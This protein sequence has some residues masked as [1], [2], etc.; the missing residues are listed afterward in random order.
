MKRLC[1]FLACLVLV[2]INLVQAQTVRI[3]GTVKSSEDGMPIPGVSVIVKGTTTGAAT[4]IDGKYELNVAADAQTLVFSSVGFKSQEVEIG[5]RSL[6]DITLQSE[7]LQVEELVVT[8]V[9]IKRSS[10]SVGYAV[11][12]VNAENATA[13]AEPD[14]LKSIQGRVPGVDVR[15]GQGAP[16]SAT[17]ISIRGTSSFFGSNQPL[18]VVDGVPYS[19]DQ[20]TTSSM[21]SG[22]GAYSN[23]LSTLDPNNIESM[24]VLK[25]SAASALYGSRAANGVLV[26]KT[27][28]GAKSSSKRGYEVTFTSSY[29]IE[30][31]AN[32]PKYQNSYGNGANFEFSNANGS[33]GARFGTIDSIPAWPEYLANYPELYSKTG[34]QPY[35]AYPNN[36]KDLFKTGSIMENSISV[37]GGSE[38]TGFNT[39]V[40]MMKQDGYIP[41]STFDRNS[42]SAGGT[43]KLENGLTVGGNLA[44]TKTTQTGGIFGENQV[45]GAASSFARN[46]FLGRCWDIPNLPYE[47]KTGLPIS[48]NSAQYD[49]PLWSF[50]H[51]TV[52]T[53]TD[54]IVAGINLEYNVF[55][56]L[57]LSYSL[58]SN[59]YRLDRKEVI[60]IGSRAASKL[61][62]VK[63]D[64]Y[65][66]REF[67]SNF[68]VT[69]SQKIGEDISLKAILGHNANTR[70]TLR[71]GVIGKKII[72]PG[73]FNMANVL[74]V[75]NNGHGTSERALW[76]LLG[77]FS[78]GYKNWLFF[79]IQARNDFSSTLPEDKRSYFY[80]SYSTSFIFSEALGLQNDIFNL[81]KLRLGYAN[82]G[83]D[84][85]PYSLENTYSL[86]TPFQ[87]QPTIYNPNTLNNP[88]LKP[89]KSSETEIGLELQFLKSRVNLDLTWYNKISTD[90]IAEVPIPPT[91][92]YYYMYQ[93]FGKMRNRGVELG[94]TL[95]PLNMNN[96]LRWEINTTFTK[97]ANEVLELKEGVDRITIPGAT[98]A[99]TP[100]I[101]KG[102]PYGSFRGTYA[103][104][105]ANG[106]LIIN[107]TTGFPYKSSDEKVLGDPNPDFVMGVNNTIS[108]KGLSL[109]VLFDWRK[110]GDLYSVTITSLLGRGVTQDTEDRA[111][112]VIV[113]GVI[114][115]SNGT[116]IVDGSGNPIPNS[117][118]ITV[119]DLYFYGGGGTETSFAINSAGEFQMYDATIY[120][121]REVTLNYD[122]PKKW[123]E[124]AKIGRISIGIYGRNLWYFAPN[125]PKYTRFDTDVNSYGAT[126]LQGFDLSSA[127]TSRRFGA[128]IKLTF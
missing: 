125:V 40:S 49:N 27:K 99:L 5:G 69:F 22:G 29:A 122:L 16:G 47:T 43:T 61:G 108:W 83:N 118:A 104:R 3:T 51:N 110:G 121:L 7:T 53:S 98:G 1:V 13:K 70:K 95:V 36:V 91:S 116:L 101:E 38:K 62:Q 9:G 50:K 81:G 6:I 106:N 54:R 12:T 63:T 109:G 119:N 100:V 33:W 65:E 31:I 92:G 90:M 84:A 48:T 25:G 30:N 35:K 71:Q 85:D 126:N 19:N 120:R 128:N 111:H 34:M 105:D 67:E 82:V 56:W 8:A 23:G 68:L 78:I 60:D 103:L 52:N 88:N 45:D 94:L 58:G 93:N 102:Y 72:V 86:S 15:V 107:P 11:S 57:N 76:A 37:S 79:N 97:N 2:G 87:G 26:I 123:F 28:S 66:K 113:P 14:L 10:K 73:I 80:S 18:I 32:L 55:S 117:T 114:G 41:E 64:Y 4:N 17:K 24:S 112:A 21:S 115:N 74:E 20:V 89:E 96:G 59:F 44:Y 77:D 75:A 46:L 42:I 127:P 39:T 124:K